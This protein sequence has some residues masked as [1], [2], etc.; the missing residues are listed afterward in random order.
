VALS[1]H[2]CRQQAE[3]IQNLENGHVRTIGQGK[4]RR[5]KYKRLKLGIGQAYNHSTDEA[6]VVA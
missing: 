5:R 2:K 6:A 1:Q 4:A 3:V